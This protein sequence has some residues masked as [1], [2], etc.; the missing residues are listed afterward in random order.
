MINAGS[1]KVNL[2]KKETSFYFYMKLKRQKIKAVSKNFVH[3]NN[4]IC[5]AS[6]KNLHGSG[7]IKRE[8][9]VNIF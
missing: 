4:A 8:K 7:N 9:L 1:R 5:D 2:E 3:K 6:H